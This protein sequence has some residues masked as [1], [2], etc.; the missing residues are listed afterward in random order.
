MKQIKKAK[1]K[2]FHQEWQELHPYKDPASSDFY[3]V[4]LSNTFLD[5]IEEVIP[6]FSEKTK[7]RIALSVAAYFEDI[8]SE[9]G[10]WQGF[11]R[12]HYQMYGKYL[13]FYELTDFYDPEYVNVEDIMFLIWSILQK[14]K[15][16]TNV[17]LNPENPV[18]IGLAWT[19]FLVLENSYETAPENELLC[20]FFTEYFNYDDFFIFRTAASWFYYHSYLMV[21]YTEGIL[22]EALKEIES[23]KKEHKNLLTYSITNEL[24]FKN[25]C[26][27]LALK[28]HEWFSAIVGEDTAL[29]KMLLQTQFKY[30]H[31]QNYLITDI[32]DK[33]VYF[34]PFDSDD[35]IFLLKS[36]FSTD[37][38]YKTGDVVKCNV[39]Y[40]NEKWELNGVIVNTSVEDYKRS[41]EE[42]E[43]Q[44]NNVAYSINLFLK[45]NQNKPI[46]YFKNGEECEDFFKKAFNFPEKT[47]K[48]FLKENKNIVSFINENHGVTT[49]ENIALYIKDKDNPCYDKEAAE[50]DGLAIIIH[51]ELFRE[52]IDYLVKKKCFSYL[53]FN[54]LE[55]EKHGKKL[56]QDNLDFL[57]RFFQPESYIE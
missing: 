14:E 10:L 31:P 47:K 29:G 1:P 11:T 21:T 55:G 48:N 36:T 9:F 3:F 33:G 4:K 25:P 37:L 13:P 54:S 51:F 27:P 8:I 32:N 6:S 57:F 34:L 22:K 2:I 19:M 43:K 56:I 46:R 41:R 15:I 35:S 23:C 12:K 7:K 38:P 16:E 20:N 28:T 40:Y 45:A 42:S 5:M 24:I 53:K 50:Q 39:I 18:I 26:G 44:K 17:V 30:E 52:L 49:M